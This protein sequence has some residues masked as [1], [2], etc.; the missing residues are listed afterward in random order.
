MKNF[1]KSS[2]VAFMLVIISATWSLAQT[3]ISGTVVEAGSGDPIPGVNV[4]V[5][6]RVAGTISG[7]NGTF[8]LTSSD[9][10]PITLIFSYVG[11]STQELVIN[12]TNTTGLSVK[13]EEQTILGQEVVIS[14]SRVEE[15]IL[16]SP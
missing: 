13:M 9:A 8:S 14:A 2:L 10:P 12:E 6:G 3:N 1:C 11:Y 16:R 7:G 5:K 4:V 15:S